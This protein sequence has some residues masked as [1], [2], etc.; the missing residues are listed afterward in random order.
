M[1]DLQYWESNNQDVS[2]GREKLLSNFN[3]YFLVLV[4]LRLGLFVKDIANHFNIS[5]CTVSHFEHGFDLSIYALRKFPYG[6]AK[7]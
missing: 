2:Y 7:I 5:T 1:S 3:E 6:Q 4:R